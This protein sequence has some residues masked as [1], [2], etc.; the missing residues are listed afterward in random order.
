MKL[1][2][3]SRLSTGKRADSNEVG[4]RGQRGVED[5]RWWGLGVRRRG[6]GWVGWGGESGFGGGASSARFVWV[7]RL[8]WVRNVVMVEPQF[9]GMTEIELCCSEEKLNDS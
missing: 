1:V 5:G 8:T 3:Q 2:F 7:S 6:W 4:W 9:G